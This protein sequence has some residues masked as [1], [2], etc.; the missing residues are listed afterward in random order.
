MAS[1]CSEMFLIQNSLI[2]PEPLPS[3]IPGEKNYSHAL[4]HTDPATQVSGANKKLYK[5][6][7]K[8]HGKQTSYTWLRGFQ[9]KPDDKWNK[10]W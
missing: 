9:T 10:L 2:N 5:E 1:V 3:H 4:Y 8:I 7:F 6:K